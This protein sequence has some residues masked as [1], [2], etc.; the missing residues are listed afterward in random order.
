MM[1]KIAH[2]FVNKVITNRNLN[3]PEERNR[4]GIIASVASIVINLLLVVVK[5]IMGI[6]VNSISLVADAAHSAC[7][8]DL[9]ESFL[10]LH[11]A[12][13]RRIRWLRSPSVNHSIHMKTLVHTVC[14]QP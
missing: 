3:K 13:S 10:R 11:V 4:L 7:L 2:R 9:R 8:A 1:K 5:L 14:G 12:R 6:I